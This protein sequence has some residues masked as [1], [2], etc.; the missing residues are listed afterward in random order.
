MNRGG[1]SI[2]GFEDQEQ[3]AK[4]NIK[5]SDFYTFPKERAYVMDRQSV[6]GVALTDPCEFHYHQ[7]LTEPGSPSVAPHLKNFLDAIRGVA[8]LNCPGEIA[9]KTAVA[10]QKTH[11]SIKNARKIHFTKG[12][13]QA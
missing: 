6:L 12:D 7:L 8:K 5:A 11:E 9:Y 1:A 13:F 10:V 2:L 4:S 3:L